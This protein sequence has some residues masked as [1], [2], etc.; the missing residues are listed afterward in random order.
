MSKVLVVDDNAFDRNLAGKLLEKGTGLTVV[1]AADGKE[2]LVVIDKE[3]PDLVVTD[4]QMPEMSGLELVEEIKS[5]HPSLPVILMT[6]HGSEEIAMQALRKGA[7]SYVPKR[8]LAQDLVETIEG[9]LGTVTANQE[10]KRL[11]ECLTHTESHFLFHNDP[12]LI[13]PLLG[14]LQDNLTRMQLCDEIGRIRVTVA[15][16]EALINA[17][18]HGNLEVSSALKE[19]SEDAYDKLIEERRRQKPYRDRRVYVSTRESPAEATY[20][21][22]D[23]GQ[24]FDYTNLP[25][26]TDPANVE[27]VSGRG[28]FLIRTFMDEVHHNDK[29][30]E[31][32]MIKRRD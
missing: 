11:L 25:N 27:K 5:K 3:E 22:R 9:V 19:T 13:A 15:I 26:P 30:N 29:G 16:R 21:I 20:I 4:L 23:E 6:A 32:T 1:H 8:N 24:G 18:H 2:A 31:I 17:I 14:H 28:L 7:A 12:S 10:Q